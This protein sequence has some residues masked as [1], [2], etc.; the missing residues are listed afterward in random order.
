MRTAPSCGSTWSTTCS[1]RVSFGCVFAG[2]WRR[3]TKNT[4]Q[5]ARSRARAPRAPPTRPAARCL[6]VACWDSRRV[7]AVAA[8]ARTPLTRSPANRRVCLLRAPCDSA[9]KYKAG[10]SLVEDRKVGEVYERE[11]GKVEAQVEGTEKY[12]VSA[13]LLDDG[14]WKETKCSCP[15][16]LRTDGKC[17]HVAAVLL[18]AA[19]ARAVGSAGQAHGN[20]KPQSDAD[21]V[22]CLDDD[23]VKEVKPVKPVNSPQCAKRAAANAATTP[24]PDGAGAKKKEVPS[25]SPNPKERALKRKLPDW[26]TGGAAAP[27]KKAA[28]TAAVARAT[29]KLAK[30]ALTKGKAQPDDDDEDCVSLNTEPKAR[31]TARQAPSKGK[32]GRS[33]VGGAAS[34]SSSAARKATDYLPDEMGIDFLMELA[35]CEDQ[36]GADGAPRKAVPLRRCDTLQKDG[37]VAQPIAQNP[38]EDFSQSGKQLCS[39]NAMTS[40]L[41]DARNAEAL[42]GDTPHR[43][44][45]HSSQSSAVPDTPERSSPDANYPCTGTVGDGHGDSSAKAVTNLVGRSDSDS[46]SD[47]DPQEAFARKFQERMRG[48]G[49]HQ[50]SQT[51]ASGSTHAEKDGEPGQSGSAGGDHAKSSAGL[52]ASL[53]A[54]TGAVPVLR[55][56]VSTDE[57]EDDVTLA[58]LKQDR[59]S[60]LGVTANSRPS[61]ETDDDISPPTRTRPTTTSSHVSA[62]PVISLADRMKQVRG[63]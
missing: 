26:M 29:A 20:S 21:A 4:P 52:R 61:S 34:C 39:K 30:D 17:K 8:R 33:T 47:E 27:K 16:G 6:A 31:K 49:S 2:G 56:A 48:K 23:D 38:A 19:S 1:G 25:P 9:A 44:S 28:G 18:K 24:L 54:S 12:E 60:A 36:S 53:K 11:E 43:L 3:P 15:D 32:G 46:D 51:A 14:L 5:A 55:P 13:I 63:F 10:K 7:S 45:K 37:S 50:N 62:K 58:K 35:G 40:C 22:I 42:A 59:P 41:A 57:E